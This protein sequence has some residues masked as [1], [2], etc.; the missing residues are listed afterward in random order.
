MLLGCACSTTA[1]FETRKC[2]ILVHAQKNGPRLIKKN[3]E[4]FRILGV[5]VPSL[6]GHMLILLKKR[7]RKCKAFF[8][9][10]AFSGGSVST[11]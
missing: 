2:L 5:R 1:H 3:V 6:R 7:Y 9:E 8:N 4:E 10:T 11:S